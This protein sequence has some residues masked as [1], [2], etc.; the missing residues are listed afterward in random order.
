LSRLTKSIDPLNRSSQFGYDDLNRLVSSVDALAGESSQGFDADGNK[1]SLLDPNDNK[2]QFDFD[3]SGR[4]VQETGASGDKVKYTYNAN[5]LL[6]SVVNG[7]EQER[8]FEYDAIGRLTRW[9]DPDGSVSY[10]YDKNGNVLTVTD[11]NGTITREYDKLNR[12]TKY[13][14][15]R[16]NILQYAFDEV[17]NLVTLTY[18][19]DKQVHYEYDAAGQL[20]SVTDWASRLTSYT[21]DKNGRLKTVTRPNGIKT[22][23]VYNRLGQLVRQ[24]DIV[25]SFEFSYDA[26]GNIVTEKTEPEADPNINLE[27]AYQAANRLATVDEKVVQFDADG[28]MTRGPLSGELTNFGFDSRNR[29][30]QAGDTNYH[31]DAENQ[32]IGVNQIQYVVNSQPALSQVL[33]Q[34]DNG[35]KTFYVYGLGLIGQES[36]GEYLSYHFDFRGSTV[37]LTDDTGN[38]TE[39]FQ[40]SPYGVL[41]SGDSSITPFLFN[42]MYGVMTDSNG[43]Y[44]MRA[45]FYSPEIRRFVNQD[46][47]LGDIVEGQTLNRYAFVTGQ[48]VSYIDPF[49]L[50]KY[51]GRCAPGDND[52]LLYGG[53]LCSEQ[54]E[55]DHIPRPY[56]GASSN[57]SVHAVA[58]GGTYEAS[59]IVDP[60]GGKTC[61]ISTYCAVIGP[62]IYGGT[63]LGI[64]AG[65]SMGDIESYLGGLSVGLGGDLAV[66]QSVGFEGSCGIDENGITS[67]GSS[68]SFLKGG[69]GFWFG[70]TLC[71]ATIVECY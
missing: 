64:P 17:G 58:I 10:T 20:V 44:Y 25:A 15:T 42:G 56:A 59:Y 62:G 22:T 49:G 27:M 39:R 11:A 6:E 52:C 12:V 40:Y 34:E 57:V 30:V 45:R 21:Y 29:L 66:I 46:I 48:P 53:N 18:P 37:A 33:V 63:S 4:L 38:V 67:L 70:I 51:C 9:T 1:E 47:L 50:A 3:L 71:N 41:L 55:D 19:D 65:M 16:G 23:R 60:I 32:R 68:K 24:S 31:Y 43:L 28:N 13:T 2:T 35:Q 54:P 26:A 36:N 14:D 5:D 69:F 8:Q 61:K 7:R